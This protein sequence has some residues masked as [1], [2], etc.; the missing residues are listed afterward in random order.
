MVRLFTLESILHYIRIYL[1][2]LLV[3]T[4]ASNILVYNSLPNL[5]VTNKSSSKEKL[6]NILYKVIIVLLK[7][8]LL[9]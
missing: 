5:I 1:T 3:N 8:I 7:Q 6:T 9:K 4:K 2:L